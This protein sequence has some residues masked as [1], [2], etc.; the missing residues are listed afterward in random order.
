MRLSSSAL[1]TL[2]PVAALL[3]GCAMGNQGAATAAPIASKAI[4]GKAFGGQQ[5]VTGST[6][7]LYAYGTSGYG[8]AGQLL[9][10]TT[11]DSGGYFTIDP[12]SINCPTPTTPVYILSLGGNPGTNTNNP[13]IALASG[14]G[15]CNNAANAFVTINEIST[16]AL[17]YTMS[18]FFAVGGSDGITPDHFGAP[19]SLTQAVTNVNSGEL[20]TLLDVEN[21]YPRQN[22]S[23]FQF[24]GSKLI[25]IANIMASCV[26]SAGPTSPACSQLA[27]YTTPPNGSAPQN[28]LEAVVNLARNPAQ[29]VGTIFNFQPQSGAA[30]FTGGLTSAP[31]DWTLA[32]SYTSP[33]FGL[34]VNT[35]TVSTIDI[36]R[37]GRVWFP[38]NGSTGGGV[39]YF[40]PSS[41]TFSPLFGAPV[42]HPQQV[43]IDVDGYVWTNDTASPNIA[44]FP[45][46]NPTA[47]VTFSLP[48]T[49]STSLTVMYD[50][51]LRYG[52]VNSYDNAPA[53]AV[54]T[55]KNAY[56]QV[57]NSTVPGSGNYLASS[58]AADVTGGTAIAGQL[59]YSPTL[60]D[61]YNAPNGAIQAPVEYQTYEDA[62]QI[63]FTGRDFIQTRGGYSTGN[64]GLCIFSTQNCFSMANQD[65]RHPSGLAIDGAGTLWLA[66][67]DVGSVEEVV[68]SSGSYLNSNQLVPDQVFFH[69]SGNGGTLT[70]PAGIAVDQTGNVWVS[71]YG[72]YGYGCTPGS[73][74]LSEIIGAGTPTITPVSEQIV[75]DDLAGTEPGLPPD[76]DVLV[77]QSG[78]KK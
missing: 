1:G 25:T 40:D 59:S 54:V 36:D 74:T 26:N 50:N 72:C 24:E 69:N 64:D 21:G 33:A 4:T 27:Y 28:T 6:I 60:F 55:G 71:N 7:A 10:T 52:I 44:G 37:T 22:S 58:L 45:G 8:S 30:A 17:A 70:T 75:I 3:S 56:A 51:S 9:A 49:V 57:P 15:P 34:G 19:A 12:S 43:A 11:T 62:G 39:G 68:P 61:I 46:S 41:G 14:L 78:T 48:G 23:T 42:Q 18:H 13:A 31:L 67:N 29:N 65:V 77:R 35:F 66:D 53:L 47:P 2:L 5:P 63:V 73:F 16:A 38:S 32:A 76:T 20:N